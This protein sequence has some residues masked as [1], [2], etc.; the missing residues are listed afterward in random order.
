MIQTPCTQPIGELTALVSRIL[1][2]IES[3]GGEM[4]LRDL[5]RRLVDLIVSIKPN[6][7]VTA[8][9]EDLFAAAAA[10]VK[11]ASLHSQPEARKRRLL[12]DARR[13]F[14]DRVVWAEPAIDV[15]TAPRE[16]RSILLAA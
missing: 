10:M 12:R 3:G 15:R 5:Q 2:A 11:D 4:N 13:R 16:N 8:A 6:P 9:A 1:S 7:G 14:D